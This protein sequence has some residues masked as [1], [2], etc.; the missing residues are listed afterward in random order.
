MRITVHF[1]PLPSCVVFT[2][3]VKDASA[4]CGRQHVQEFLYYR[5]HVLV[6][7]VL[8]YRRCRPL[9]HRQIRREH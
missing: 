5:G 8:R 9:R 7:A 3:D 6:V 2:G 1:P 4:N